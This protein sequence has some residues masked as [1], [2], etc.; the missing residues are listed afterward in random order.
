M[1]APALI[2][3]GASLLGGVLG[4]RARRKEAEK[5]RSFQE[6]MSSTS[7]QRGVA[8]MNAAGLNP[9][10]AYG[11]GGASSPGG[12]MAQQEDVISGAVSSAMAAKRLRQELR[13]MK[14]QENAIYNESRYKMQ[15][16][17]E[18]AHRRELL[19]LQ[20]DQTRINN[21]LLELQ[22][23]WMRATARAAEKFPEAAILKLITGSG[24][25]GLIGST[26]GAAGYAGSR[27]S[28]RRKGGK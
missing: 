23:P 11:K 22:L 25:A 8:D 6:R 1:V 27:L 21:Q 16:T 13:N 18:S 28:D 15:L 4:N 9:A 26:I 14:E 17:E 2:A 3:G 19:T 12:S 7:W 10:L 20:Q 24:G 5:N